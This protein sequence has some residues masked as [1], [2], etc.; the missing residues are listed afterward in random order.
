MSGF[1]AVET[2]SEPYAGI[3]TYLEGSRRGVE[4]RTFFSAQ[5]VCPSAYAGKVS[6]V[7]GNVI[8]DLNARWANNQFNGAN[9]LYYVEFDSGLLADIQDTVAA[10]HSLVL[11]GNLED[12]VRPEDAY[13]VR[14][15]M[16]LA[17]MFGH[18]NEIG[19]LAATNSD[20]ADNVTIHV[21]ELQETQTFY[22]RNEPGS[23]GWFRADEAPASNTVV[24]PEQG[25]ILRRKG[26]GRITF[27]QHGAV[28]RGRFLVPILEGTN[29][30]G[31]VKLRKNFKLAELNLY[32]G[33]PTTGFV[34][35]D[36][37]EDADNIVVVNP[38]KGTAK[39]Y[40]YSTNYLGRAGWFDEKYRSASRAVVPAGSAF[41]VLRKS[42]H[43]MFHWSVP[44]SP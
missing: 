32:T 40:F 5:C 17:D 18:T 28:K 21:P 27:F 34:A 20:D 30:V 25:L 9:G 31:T 7:Q 36:N 43:G 38:V 41:Y 3:G 14:R 1:A 26:A 29:L 4:R 10:N 6:S 8:I 2:V 37:L 24:F 33:D 13:R 12:V 44:T 42:S 11:V 39:T 22:Y 23:E 35:A 16:T 19:F 15:H